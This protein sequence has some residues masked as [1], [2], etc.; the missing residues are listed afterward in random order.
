M[1]GNTG[2]IVTNVFV[3]GSSVGALNSYTFNNVVTNH[4][5]SAYFG[6]GVVSNSWPCYRGPNKDGS[7]TET[8]AGWPP[9]EIWRASIGQGYSEVIVGGGK[10]YTMGYSN[11][12]DQV[13]CF[14]ETLSTGTNPPVLWQ[15]QYPG[16]ATLS[17]GCNGTVCTPTL[18]GT[19]LYTFS[20]T[21]LVYC[22]NAATGNTN[23][24]ALV[25]VGMPSYGFCGSP[26]VEGSNVIV[27]ANTYGVAL[28]KLTGQTNWVSAAGNAGGYSSPYALTVGTQRT[29]VVFSSYGCFGVDPASG[30]VLWSYAFP[31]FGN[32]PGSIDPIIYNNQLW[33][34]QNGNCGGTAALVNLGSGVLSS[35]VWQ[36]NSLVGGC[37]DNCSV[38][39]N[40][41]IYGPSYPVY[42]YRRLFVGY[43]RRIP[44]C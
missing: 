1:S 27:N 21:G 44:M 32:D 6:V 28:N 36:T 29:V 26:L 18:D 25:N 22:F 38:L 30:T 8:V 13:Y 3:D 11:N 35:V 41:Y 43:W 10:V 14:S 2:Y 39:Y 24:S 4:T 5:I 31:G 7:T 12:H 33:V 20:T 40:G 23:W 16:K 37:G 42:V 19:N 9:K 17:V 15:A 34:A